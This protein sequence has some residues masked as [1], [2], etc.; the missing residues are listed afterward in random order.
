MSQQRWQNQVRL[1]LLAAMA[2]PGVN[3]QIAAE[4]ARVEVKLKQW[5]RALKQL[6]KLV[7]N[8]AAWSAAAGPLI[9]G[10][11]DARKKI[12]VSWFIRRNRQRLKRDL[13]CWG[14]TGYALLT[15][16]RYRSVV[17][18]LAAW[19]TRP[20]V[21]PWMLTNLGVALAM[22]GRYEEAAQVH[23]SAIALPADQTTPAQKIYLAAL[24]A[25][26]GRFE[27]AKPL[28]DQTAE[29]QLK[30]FPRAIRTLVAEILSLR[31]DEKLARSW[32]PSLDARIRLNRA[33]RPFAKLRASS[34]F[35]RRTQSRIVDRLARDRGWWLLWLAS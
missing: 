5:Q 30:D 11:A 14:S 18:W 22:L 15:I 29:I 4:W 33:L 3:P 19:K 32:F 9:S 16:G 1:T 24:E 35:M 21:Q 13:S 7:G 23:R 6:K 25:G 17:K 20:G 8:D 28:V 26:A 27:V 12:A 2:K 34:R 10:M 31:D